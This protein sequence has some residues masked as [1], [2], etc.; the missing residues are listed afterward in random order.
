MT[1]LKESKAPEPATYFMLGCLG[2]EKR[3]YEIDNDLG[4]DCRGNV[5]TVCFKTKTI[6]PSITDIEE[7]STYG[8]DIY[9][10]CITCY[11]QHVLTYADTPLP[12]IMSIKK[13][14]ISELQNHK[15]P[16]MRE[17]WNYIIGCDYIALVSDTD[18]KPKEFKSKYYF[19]QYLS[20]DSIAQKIE[21]SEIL[22]SKT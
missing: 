20:D 12:T 10:C 8:L 3:F 16:K 1:D 7:F 17:I 2:F 15:D 13:Q 22:A 6:T 11:K 4:C 21:A 18:E 19:G 9:V 14:Y 5:L